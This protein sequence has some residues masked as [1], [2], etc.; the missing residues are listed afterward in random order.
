VSIPII[1]GVVEPDP[2]G[3]KAY[4]LVFLNGVGELASIPVNSAAEAEV[5]AQRIFAEMDLD[6]F[7]VG[8][9]HT[10]K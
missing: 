6:A 9:P 5:I 10:Q 8:T 3:K 1:K 2:A 4:R 7:S